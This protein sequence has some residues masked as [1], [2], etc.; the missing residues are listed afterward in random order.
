M[1]QT[2]EGGGR[3]SKKYDQLYAHKQSKAQVAAPQTSV[4]SSE[5]FRTHIISYKTVI[6]RTIPFDNSNNIIKPL[7]RNQ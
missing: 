4:I 1:F 7:T 5:L 3:V 6:I 2:R